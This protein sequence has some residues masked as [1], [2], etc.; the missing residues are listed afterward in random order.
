MQ[1]H[2]KYTLHVTIMLQSIYYNNLLLCSL[3][4][5]VHEKETILLEYYNN[6]AA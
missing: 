3:V 4:C 2:Q 1:A 6:I 5:I